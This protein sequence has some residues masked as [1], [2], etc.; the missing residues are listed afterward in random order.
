ML[1]GMECTI[2]SHYW[3]ELC[4]IRFRKRG[5]ASQI[6]GA[7]AG[8]RAKVARAF[9]PR[10]YADAAHSRPL[11]ANDSGLADMLERYG[12]LVGHCHL[13]VSIKEAL[14]LADCCPGR[15]LL[16][17]NFRCLGLVI[18]GPRIVQIG[19]AEVVHT[20][21]ACS[22]VCGLE[23]AR[24]LLEHDRPLRD[25]LFAVAAIILAQYLLAVTHTAFRGR[26]TRWWPV[27]ETPLGV[28]RRVAADREEARMLVS[29]RA[30]SCVLPP[31]VDRWRLPVLTLGNVAAAC[32]RI[33]EIRL[34]A[35]HVL[36]AAVQLLHPPMLRCSPAQIASGGI[37]A[38]SRASESGLSRLLGT[39][40]L[41]SGARFRLLENAGVISVETSTAKPS[42]R[43]W[44]NQT[45]S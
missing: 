24:H 10:C 25:L 44:G 16:Q 12:V 30:S 39:N 14:L 27:R 9:E 23:R 5:E 6:V 19:R 28:G 45:S 4:L 35:Y 22:D 8:R 38:V 41:S 7:D 1:A 17:I 21:R 15:F 32:Q 31:E 37:E 20:R 26:N 40:R 36:R 18:T 42:C 2:E 43:S 29:Y 13:L 34:W 11:S 33:K 3:L